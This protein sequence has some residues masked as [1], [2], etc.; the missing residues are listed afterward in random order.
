MK[1]KN[2]IE[3][4]FEIESRKIEFGVKETFDINDLTESEK[5]NIF[6]STMGLNVTFTLEEALE[7]TR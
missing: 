7:L 1:N 2:L 6:K 3:E 4:D 5:E